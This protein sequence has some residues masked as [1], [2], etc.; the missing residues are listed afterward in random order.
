MKKVIFASFELWARL[1]T[2][3]GTLAS[4]AEFEKREHRMIYPD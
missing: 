1:T 2:P 4:S 3:F